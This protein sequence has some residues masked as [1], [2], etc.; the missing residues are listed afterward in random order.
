VLNAS[1]R[2]I[3]VYGGILAAMPSAHPEEEDY[4]G[5]G[6]SNVIR[7]LSDGSIHIEELQPEKM[8]FHR[9]LQYPNRC[10]FA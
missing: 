8:D 5:Y 2:N 1:G 7:N 9:I 4:I 10:Y 6:F 3:Y